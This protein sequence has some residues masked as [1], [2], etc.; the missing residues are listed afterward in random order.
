MK[1]LTFWDLVQKALNERRLKFDDK[2][3]PQMK[4]DSDPLQVA[5]TSYVEPFECMMVKALEA[6]TMQV[7][8][9]EEYAKKD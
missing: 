4:I 9:E 8:S 5:E 7:V 6:T 3:K 1:S 2:S